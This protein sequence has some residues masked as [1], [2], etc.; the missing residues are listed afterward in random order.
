MKVAALREL[1][2]KE[3]VDFFNEYV[4][5]DAPKRKSLSVQVFGGLH[6]AEYEIASK[7][8]SK[9]NK[10]TRIDDLIKFRQS[11]SLYGAFTGGFGLTNL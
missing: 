2:K 7:D 9:D 8:E 4:K 10:A 1:T 3:L 11:M 6:S 5:V